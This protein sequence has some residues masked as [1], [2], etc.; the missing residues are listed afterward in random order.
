[1]DEHLVLYGLLLTS[2]ISG[3]EGVTCMKSEI[4]R[5]VVRKT[6]F[7]C[8]NHYHCCGTKLEKECCIN[9]G[10]LVVI[11]SATGVVLMLCLIGYIAWKSRKEKSMRKE[12]PEVPTKSTKKEAPEEA[13]HKSK[14]EK[15]HRASTS[16][17]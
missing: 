17:V 15:K 14:R 13:P 11:G 12:V 5:G 4:R 10:L 9:K 2:L 7:E 3:V 1:M 6:Y 16:A 8:A